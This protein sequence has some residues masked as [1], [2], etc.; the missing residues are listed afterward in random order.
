M[1]LIAANRVRSLAQTYLPTQN[2]QLENSLAALIISDSGKIA[3]LQVDHNSLWV[4]LSLW[5]A[6]LNSSKTHRRVTGD[7]RATSKTPHCTF[8]SSFPLLHSHLVGTLQSFNGLQRIDESNI[9]DK[10]W[11]SQMIVMSN[12]FF[13]TPFPLFS[14]FE[15]IHQ[16]TTSFSWNSFYFQLKRWKHFLLGVDCARG[17]YSGFFMRELMRTSQLWDSH[18]RFGVTRPVFSLMSC[19]N[20]ADWA[21]W[22]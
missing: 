5:W 15:Q 10:P 1:P 13:H 17:C 4:V 22:H 18:K 16:P 14:P 12:V 3:R 20:A 9:I 6:G 2:C 21:P 19:N 11:A 8:K 7:W